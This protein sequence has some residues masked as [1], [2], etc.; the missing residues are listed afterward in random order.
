MDAV[1]NSIICRY[2]E[3]A[4][5]GRNRSRFENVLIE[6]MYYLLRELDGI[7]ISKVRGRV[8]IKFKDGRNFSE[9]EFA[10][11]NEQLQKAFGIESYSPVIMCEPDMDLLDGIVL[12]S[13]DRYFGSHLKT[14]DSVVSFRIRARRSDKKFP[15]SSKDVEIRLATV[16]GDHYGDER[17]R[18]DLSENAEITVYCEIREE[19]ACVFYES[20]PGPGGLPVGSNGKILAL[21]SGGIDS[22]VACYLGMKRGCHVDYI[23]F[24]SDP[25]TPPETIEKVKTLAGLLNG[26]QRPGRLFCCNLAS[27]Q[28]LIRDKC[29]PRF[30]TILYRRMMMR[31]SQTIAENHKCLALLTGE[32]VGQVA[33]QTIQNMSTINQSIEMLIIRPLAGLDKLDVI[34]ISEQIDAFEISKVQVPDSCTVF[35][36]NSPATSVTPDKILR[37]E[38]IISDYPDLLAD[39]IKNCDVISWK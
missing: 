4:I 8:F 25:Y 31:I 13:A 7:K 14:A 2:S 22:P 28:K 29:N 20:F 30:R 21:L 1:Y 15:L 39:I 19:F 24:H 32:S 37:E 5:K 34:R 33:S 9:E 27:I 23:T 3:I 26:Y 16:I 18:I 17:L 10:I 6:N 35:A 36:P 38:K 11:I 12:K